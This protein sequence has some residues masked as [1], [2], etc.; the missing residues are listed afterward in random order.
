MPQVGIIG[1]VLGGSPQSGSIP[2][3]TVTLQQ[4][5]PPLCLFPLPLPLPLPPSP[6]PPLSHSPSPKSASTN[7]QERVGGERD[8]GWGELVY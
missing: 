8:R 4:R 7:T 2:D 5:S 3:G 6:F 1:L